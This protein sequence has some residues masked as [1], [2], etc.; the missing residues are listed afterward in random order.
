M[1]GKK[2]R[3]D[4]IEF[5][6]H[7]SDE[8][9]LLHRELEDK[10]YRHGPY[11]AFKINDPKPR[12][13]HK[14]S[15]R[16]RLIYHAVHR[17]LYPYFDNKFIYDSYSCRLGKGT[18]KAINRFCNYARKISRNNMRTVWVLK[19]DIRKFFAS[20]DH[21]VLKN[22]FK[23]YIFDANT[24]WLLGQLI[25]SFY[26]T[27]KDGVGLPLGNLTSQLFVNIY[28]N[29]FDQFVKRKLK[30]TYYIRYADDFVILSESRS[31]LARLIPELSKF[32]ENKLRLTLHP[33]K[34]FIKTLASGVDFLGWV[35]FPRHLVPRTSTKKRVIKRLR[36]NYSK[37]SLASYFGLLGHGDTFALTQKL[38]RLH[39]DELTN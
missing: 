2:K 10:T 20:I 25:G 37:Q 3:K 34:L 26:T 15:V 33:K 23:K 28:L 39:Q 35:I 36:I 9:L 6:L 8:I 12:D 14:A 32:L 13:I 17:V 31:Y 1:R 11:H 29:E 4:V 21:E 24:L 16:D 5:A 18:H 27:G 7:L 22:I 38:R 30:A 19:G